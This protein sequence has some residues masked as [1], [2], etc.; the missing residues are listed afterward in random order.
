MSKKPAPPTLE[1]L[2]AHAIV[3][4][5]GC[6]HGSIDGVLI[7]VSFRDAEGATMLLTDQHGN[8]HTLDGMR[9]AIEEGVTGDPP[10]G[11]CKP[12]DDHDDE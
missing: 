4:I 7:Y 12:A 3:D 2:T 1:Q 11:E 10:V 8:D 5:I 6:Q 9:R